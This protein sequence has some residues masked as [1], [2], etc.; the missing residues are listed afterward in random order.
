MMENTEADPDEGAPPGDGDDEGGKASRSG[1]KWTEQTY[2]EKGYRRIVL[3][4]PLATADAFDAIAV[5]LN[6][7]NRS[8]AFIEIISKIA[9]KKT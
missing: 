4:V 9:K 8:K 5:G 2:A 1:S 7:G 6:G 3:R